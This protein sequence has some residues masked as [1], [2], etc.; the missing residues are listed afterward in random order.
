MIEEERV[1]EEE[2]EVEKQHHATHDQEDVSTAAP[3]AKAN[4][5][6]DVKQEAAASEETVYYNEVS[7][8]HTLSDG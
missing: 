6:A 2:G 1:A 3:I 4:N 7:V 5:K 8:L